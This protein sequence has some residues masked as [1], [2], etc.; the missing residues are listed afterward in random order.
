MIRAESGTHLPPVTR[1]TFPDRSGRSLLGS[2]VGSGFLEKK[3][4]MVGCGLRVGTEHAQAW[5]YVRN[6]RRDSCG[7]QL[8]SAAS[9]ESTLVVLSLAGL[10]HKVLVDMLCQE[11]LRPP[12]VDSAMACQSG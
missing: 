3:L 10:R 12:S 9:I 6:P 8:V 11:D 1:I 4:L 5:P 7:F 2:K